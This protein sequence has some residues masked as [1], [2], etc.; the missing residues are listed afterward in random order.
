MGRGGADLHSHTTFSDGKT[1]LALSARAAE[2][3]GLEALAITDHQWQPGAVAGGAA[4][5]EYLAAIAAVQAR[6][7]VRLLRGVES[8]AVDA[9]GTPAID[10]ETARPLD[11]VLC[12]MGGRTR[13]LFVDGPSAQTAFLE[14]LRRAMVAICEHPL[15]DVFAH[16]FN[17]GRL[18]R[19]LA[20]ATLPVRLVEEVCAAAAATGTAFE[21]MNDMQYWF[22]ELSV[23][24]L[25][26]DYAA[27][28]A[29]AH[30]AGCRFTLGSDA[31][32][33]QGVGNLRWSRRVLDLAGV[34]DDRLTDWRTFVDHTSN[35]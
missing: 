15:V 3:A 28:V 31:H 20:P 23:A 6:T 26:G 27:I 2:A 8:T 7:P 22:P 11:L 21:V 12:D 19:D 14:G 35:S 9:A 34:P 30:A 32:H 18:G 16:P 13:G 5:S 10:A 25:T 17:V 4:L 33:H 29:R 24:E 1:S